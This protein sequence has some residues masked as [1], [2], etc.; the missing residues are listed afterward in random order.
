[1]IAWHQ[2]VLPRRKT[3]VGV[4]LELLVG[5]DVDLDGSAETVLAHVRSRVH[6]HRGPGS[7]VRLVVG[8][9]KK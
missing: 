7:L 8:L 4:A 6:V 5:V 1:M 9:Q 3:R 2:A